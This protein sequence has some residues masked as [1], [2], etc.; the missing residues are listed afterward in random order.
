M[1]EL[2]KMDLTSQRLTHPTNT[3]RLFANQILDKRQFFRVR[4]GGV[5]M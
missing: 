5:G 4:C 2:L 1:H 3:E